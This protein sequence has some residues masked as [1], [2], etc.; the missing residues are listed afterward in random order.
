MERS[1]PLLGP[2]A[3]KL[4]PALRMAVDGS[5]EVNV[6]RAE[7]APAMAVEETPAT[8]EALAAQLPLEQRVVLADADELPAPPLPAVPAGVRTSVFIQTISPD[9]EARFPGRGRGPQGAD[10]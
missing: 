6:A 1:G 5:L 7:Q 4:E 10:V 9:V 8:R 3:R 2:N